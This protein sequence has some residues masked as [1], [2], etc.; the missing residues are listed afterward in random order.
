MASRF[1][2]LNYG[3]PVF[4]TELYTFATFNVHHDISDYTN[5]NYES[6]HKEINHIGF[7]QKTLNINQDRKS[8]I[9]TRS[10]KNAFLVYDYFKSENLNIHEI[11]K[12]RSSNGLQIIIK[13][14]IHYFYLDGVFFMMYTTQH[15]KYI[16][17]HDF[18]EG[19][20]N[21]NPKFYEF[22]R[23]IRTYIKRKKIIKSDE[24]T[25][26]FDNLCLFD[27]VL[28]T[29]LIKII[30]YESNRSDADLNEDDPHH[31]D[32]YFN[33]INL[34]D[35][36]ENRKRYHVI[37]TY[38]YETLIKYFK[39]F[40]TSYKHILRI[41]TVDGFYK[42]FYDEFTNMIYF[43]CY[44]LIIA[45]Y[46]INT[47]KLYMVHPHECKYVNDK[48]NDFLE[49]IKTVVKKMFK[50]V[51]II[52][53]YGNLLYTHLEVDKN[54]D[55]Y[56]KM[57]CYRNEFLKENDPC[58]DEEDDNYIC[59]C[60]QFEEIPDNK[61]PLLI[62]CIK[63]DNNNYD[64]DDESDDD[65][66]TDNS[67]EKL[68][69]Y[70]RSR[71]LLDKKNNK[72]NLKELNE[73]LLFEKMILE[74]L[75][76]YY[77]S[78]ILLDKKNNKDNQEKYFNKILLFEKMIEE[79][80]LRTILI[81]KDERENKDNQE[82]L[83]KILLFENMIEEEKLRTILIIKDERE[84][85]REN[86][87][88]NSESS[89]SESD[90]DDSESESDPDDSES[91]SDP[92]DSESESDTDD[93]DDAL[94]NYNEYLM[95]PAGTRRILRDQINIKKFRC[96]NTEIFEKH[97]M[98]R[99]LFKPHYIKTTDITNYNST[100][101]IKLNPHGDNIDY[102]YS[103]DVKIAEYWFNDNSYKIGAYSNN[104][105]FN[106]Y[107]KRT[108]SQTTSKIVNKLILFL[109]TPNNYDFNYN[110]YGANNPDF[111]NGLH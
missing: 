72:D 73:I 110:I 1:L 37:Y 91:E 11:I 47:N 35:R 83:N 4:E 38:D 75:Y 68:Y 71:I 102:I 89:E 23:N 57:V 61:D 84:R 45:S 82:K 59:T 13:D 10:N 58:Y 99:T 106:D 34:Y 100:L 28:Y 30:K 85:E 33:A 105:I 88:I 95:I 27:K 40:G 107:N 2:N 26:K 53:E 103:Y 62:D 19:G 78:R 97:L 70:Y 22:K 92:D 76:A 6:N 48:V 9:Y 17:S 111:N 69:A 109:T 98:I 42:I 81:I 3:A 21:N 14:D 87:I 55:I 31:E 94:N 46:D 25:I 60:G 77:R 64:T 43:I 63:D 36:K 101:T 16:M 39:Y 67:L 51:K 5:Y 20:L 104:P 24:S 8:I 29:D 44:D 74:Q 52:F 12:F 41:D 32:L 93:E 90:T 79:E 65:E 96:A 7:Y 108:Y 66:K 54:D 49:N 80:K 50:N 18:S 86:K 56:G 15:N